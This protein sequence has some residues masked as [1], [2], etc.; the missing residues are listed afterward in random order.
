M[1]KSKISK[2]W[3]LWFI[4]LAWFWSTRSKDLSTKVGAVIVDDANDV[5]SSGYNGMPRGVDDT[6]AERNHRPGKYK[7][8]EHAERNAIYNAARRVLKGTTMVL[9]YAPCP[10]TDCTRAIIQCGIKRIIISDKDFPSLTR[11]NDDLEV[12]KVML[13][14]AGVEIIKASEIEN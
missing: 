4:Q 1:E 11:W 13:K 14:E 10:C 9:Q 12:A 7:W 6:V 8:F 2:G 3:A 5:I